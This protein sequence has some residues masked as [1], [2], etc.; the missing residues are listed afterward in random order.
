MTNKH[1]NALRRER[2]ARG[3]KASY[4]AYRLGV[5]PA[6]YSQIER[7]KQGLSV[8]RLL[9][10]LAILEIKPSDFLAA[11]SATSGNG[12]KAI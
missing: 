9:R 4:V 1:G 8:D 7:E 5:S 3:L 10:I 12:K 2:E 11:D 6:T